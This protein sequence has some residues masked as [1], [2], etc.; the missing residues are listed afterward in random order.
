MPATAYIALGSN[1]GDRGQFLDQALHLLREHPRVQVGQVSSY[2]ETE[3]VGGPPGQGA[4]LNA[5]AE[6]VTDLPAPDLLRLL[7]DIERRLG[8]VRQ[9]RFGPRTIDLDLLLCGDA[10]IAEDDLNLPHPRLQERLFVL[11]PLVEIAPRVRHPGLG[12]T[13]RE[14]LQRLRRRGVSC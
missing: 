14:L 7:L 6:I 13:V 1:L 4:Y 3:P 5:A 8:R 12:L 2:H 11:R 10:T 9:E